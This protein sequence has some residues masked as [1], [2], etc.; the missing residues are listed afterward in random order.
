MPAET[1][2]R[3]CNESLR[4]VK[5]SGDTPLARFNSLID[6]SRNEKAAE[7]FVLTQER[8]FRVGI[9]NNGRVPIYNRG[10]FQLN[11]VGTVW[12]LRTGVRVI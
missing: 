12:S 6:L 2:I 1:F 11:V 7:T 5:A 4:S 3:R 8:S 10:R 9:A